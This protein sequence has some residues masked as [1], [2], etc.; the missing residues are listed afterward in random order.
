MLN[1]SFLSDEIE[2]LPLVRDKGI[3]DNIIYSGMLN[4]FN[5]EK[6]NERPI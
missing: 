3:I 5:K 1:L 6:T 4:K 2:K